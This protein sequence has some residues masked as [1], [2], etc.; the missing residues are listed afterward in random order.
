MVN[1]AQKTT[2]ATYFAKEG[3]A[4]Q[5]G[6]LKCD[7]P[8]AELV[9]VTQEVEVVIDQYYCAMVGQSP[10]WSVGVEQ[11]HAGTSAIMFLRSHTVVLVKTMLGGGNACEEGRGRVSARH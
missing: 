6:R 3:T 1:R 4:T 2:T 10:T 5:E 11:K 7:G 8:A 9:I